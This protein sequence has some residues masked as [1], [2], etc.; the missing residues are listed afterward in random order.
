MLRDTHF[1][2]ATLAPGRTWS[3]FLGL[4]L[5][6]NEGIYG[7][8]KHAAVMPAG[9]PSGWLIRWPVIRTAQPYHRLRVIRNQSRTRETLNCFRVRDVLFAGS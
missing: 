1:S 8:L 3:S 7:G 5:R 9:G 6:K 2:L 4:P